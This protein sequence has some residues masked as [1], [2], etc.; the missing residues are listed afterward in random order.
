MMGTLSE[1]LRVLIAKSGVS[2]YELA[3]Q[4]GVAESVLSRFMSR[5]HGLTLATVDRLGVVLGL[6]L[7]VS[8]QAVELPARHAKAMQVTVDTTRPTRK[9]SKGEPMQATELPSTPD[10]NEVASRYAKLAHEE[11]FS[12]RRGVWTLA[13]FGR[14]RVLCYYNNNPYAQ[15]P[16]AREWE[17]AELRRWLEENGHVEL[18]FGCHPPLQAPESPGYTTAILIAGGAKVQLQLRDKVREILERSRER[19]AR[20]SSS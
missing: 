9:R 19:Q 17:L 13:G 3:K 5:Q 20:E 12:S 8:V 2:R 15:H 7:Q 16:D 10:W 6:S 11:H 1:Q 18:G 4:V 14:Q